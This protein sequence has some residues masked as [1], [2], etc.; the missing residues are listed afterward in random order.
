MID[1]NDLVQEFLL[2][3]NSINNELLNLVDQ[4]FLIMWHKKQNNL[5]MDS[6]VKYEVEGCIGPNEENN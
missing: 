2:L 5:D 6:I 4:M 1:T 3:D